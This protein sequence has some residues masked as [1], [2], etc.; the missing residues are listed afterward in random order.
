[1]SDPPPI[2]YIV[3][4]DELS[5]S[6]FGAVLEAAGLSCRS[7]VS[8]NAFL[9][10][11]NPDQPGC[12]LLDVQMPGMTGLELQQRLNLLGAVIPVIFASGHADVPVAVQAMRDGAFDFVEKPVA[13][14]ILLARVHKALEYDAQNRAVLRQREVMTARFETLTP[15]EKEVLMLLMTGRSNKAMAS[16]LHLSQRTVELHRARIME[17][18]GSRSLAQLIRMAMTVNLSMAA[19]V[20]PSM[21]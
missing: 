20:Q 14:D 2:V 18:T 15:R 6:Y 8:A 19:P 4:D 17:K 16:D 21:S 1:M 11:Y 5:R 10:I 9:Q 3:D 12:L 13:R 7:A